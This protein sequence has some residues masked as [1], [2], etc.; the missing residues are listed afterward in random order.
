MCCLGL[1]SCPYRLRPLS[2][3]PPPCSSV[4]WPA[5]VRAACGPAAYRAVT[6]SSAAAACASSSTTT[7]SVRSWD[8]D[9][10]ERREACAAAAAAGSAPPPT[11][12]IAPACETQKKPPHL[13]ALGAAQHGTRP[14]A[15]LLEDHRV[16]RKL[17]VRHAAAGAARRRGLALAGLA[18]PLLGRGRLHRPRSRRGA[19]HRCR[20]RWQATRKSLCAPRTC[21][22]L[23]D[24]HG[25]TRRTKTNRPIQAGQLAV[26]LGAAHPSPARPA[27]GGDLLAV[28]HGRGSDHLRLG[29][30]PLKPK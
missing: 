19:S 21:P 3:T 2:P 28:R 25:P 27:N 7:R 10:R 8:C 20:G 24:G 29:R 5:P 4:G 18:A 1:D 17:A 13:H 23:S 22:T 16:R 11:T 12:R 14:A 26:W 9:G 6:S 30:G 15:S